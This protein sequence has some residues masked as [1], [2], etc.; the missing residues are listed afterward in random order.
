MTDNL[1]SLIE[2]L[3]GPHNA[4]MHRVDCYSTINALRQER[5]G[6]KG[7]AD[8]Y[9]RLYDEE[10]QRADTAEALLA[11]LKQRSDQ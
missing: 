5:D 9:M 2:R 10:R 7:Q 3:R 8:G 1:N 6:W 11:S 4:C